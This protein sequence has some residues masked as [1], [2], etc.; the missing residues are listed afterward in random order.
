[1]GNEETVVKPVKVNLIILDATSLTAT[2]WRIY[3]P[4]QVWYIWT[5]LE[6][7][8]ETMR[9]NITSYLIIIPTYMKLPQPKS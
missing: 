7:K 2:I 5:G 4:W 3:D 8:T 1:V 6:Q 9:N